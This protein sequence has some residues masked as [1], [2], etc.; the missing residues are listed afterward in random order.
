MR[1]GK[2]VFSL[3]VETTVKARIEDAWDCLVEPKKSAEFFFGISFESDLKKGSPI[4]WSGVWE[5][6]PFVDK[7]LILAIEKLRLF[8]YSYHSS[9]SGLPEPPI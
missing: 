6:R 3:D 7:G 5:G 8:S 9:S 2:E 1:N 4:T